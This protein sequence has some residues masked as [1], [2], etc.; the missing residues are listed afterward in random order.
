MKSQ[1]TQ[2][3]NKKSLIRQASATLAICS[4][5]YSPLSYAQKEATWVDRGMQIMDSAVATMQQSMQQ[6]IAS[7]QLAAQ[8]ASLQPQVIPSKYFL[9]LSVLFIDCNL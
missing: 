6:S 8:M 5:I 7:N 1:K 9:S 2:M 4:L 3:K